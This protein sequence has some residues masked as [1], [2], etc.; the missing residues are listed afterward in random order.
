MAD[1]LTLKERPR[2]PESGRHG[3][4]TSFRQLS[5]FAQVNITKQHFIR[6]ATYMQV[7]RHTA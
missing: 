6:Q 4:Q 3:I 5:S 7:R 1:W 2:V